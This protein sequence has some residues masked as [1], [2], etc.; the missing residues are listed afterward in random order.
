M[1]LGHPTRYRHEGRELTATITG[2][3]PHGRLLLTTE[4]GENLS[5]GMKE[6]EFLI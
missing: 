1:N 6:I 4:E 2:I 3:D 5:C